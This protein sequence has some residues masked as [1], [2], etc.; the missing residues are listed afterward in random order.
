MVNDMN[1]KG[2][3]L[4]ELVGSVVILSLIAVLAFPALISMLN[5]GQ[6][7]VDDSVVNVVI[8]AAKDCV[9][10]YPN[11]DDYS[12]VCTTV[13]NLCK[14]GYIS[15]SF[16]DNYPEIKNGKI[17]INDGIYAYSPTGGSGNCE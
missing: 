17:T 2:F 10:D 1:K 3:T 8:S 4:V 7:K 6:K 13:S 14:R 11:R 9:N 12:N 15:R 16:Y 5:K